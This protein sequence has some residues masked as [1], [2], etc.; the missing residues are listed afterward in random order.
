MSKTL[1]VCGGG[2]KGGYML[3]MLHELDTQHYVNYVGTSVGS[4]INLL[5]SVGYSPQD[6]LE[7]TKQRCSSW[8]RINIRHL[9]NDFGVCSF[10]TIQD[11]VIQ[12]VQQKVSSFNYNTTFNELFKLTNKSIVITLSCIDDESVVYASHTNTP[13]MSVITAL[14]ISCA[15]PGVF[16]PVKHENKLYV[17]GGVLDNVP[18]EYAK[19]T[20]PDEPI[21]IVLCKV[22]MM[23][24]DNYVHFLTNVVN[25]II[26]KQ[27]V[28]KKRSKDRLFEIKT[29]ETFLFD[30]AV[31]DF[32]TMFE[33]GRKMLLNNKS[34]DN[35]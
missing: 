35:M 3:G 11:D 16:P 22:S 24:N 10:D 6:V 8:F 17:D 18:Y 2:A 26:N 19:H 7:S 29:P 25:M 9:F 4:I 1:V 5:L 12:L 27:S 30:T 28:I 32:D 20:F 13:D 31:V 14:K 21:D 34:H 15:V 33:D 23:T